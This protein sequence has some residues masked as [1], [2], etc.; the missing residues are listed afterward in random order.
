MED[1]IFKN[2]SMEYKQTPRT[3]KTGA[4]DFSW[5]N[6][7]PAGK[8][9]F[10]KTDGENLVFEDGEKVKFFG[11]N[12]GFGAV[13]PTRRAAEAMADELASVGANFARLHAATFGSLII[14]F[15]DGT[16]QKLNA[17]NLERMDYLIY[18]LK[19]KGIY[20]HF[21]TI[22]G[23][24]YTVKDGFTQEEI[25]YLNESIV[26]A[27]RL[28]DKRCIELDRK[29]II[30]LLDH[31]NP[32][33]GLR[34]ADDPAIAIVQYANENDITWVSTVK[35]KTPFDGILN[36]LYNEWLLKKFGSRD[37]LDKEWT[38]DK[39]EKA[40][41]P[42]ED[43]AKGT[44]RHKP[45]GCWH[46]PMTN[47]TNKYSSE[48][49]SPARHAT[50]MQF[51]YDTQKKTFDYMVEAMKE[52]GVKCLIN[53]SNTVGAGLQRAMNA[54]GDVM[55]T[56][57]YW[58]HP[59][60]PYTV[61]STFHLDAMTDVDP[62]INLGSGFHT[63]SVTPVSH[64]S[65]A[66]KPLIITEWNAA[67]VCQFKADAILQVACYGALQNWSGFLLFAYSFD[68]YVDDDFFGTT[69]YTSFFNSNIDP[70]MWGQ[71]GLAA[72]IF[73]LG[74]VDEAKRYV[75]I[76]VDKTD[77]WVQSPEYTKPAM[78]I[79]F[80]SKYKCKFFDEKY[81][82][83]ADLTISGG[84][85]SSGDY[86]SANHLLLQSFNEYSDEMQKHPARDGWLAKHTEFGANLE[87]LGGF[88]CYV[89]EKHAVAAGKII[90][91]GC[92]EGAPYDKVFTA[93]MRRFGLLS[94]DA[95]WFEDKVVSDTKQLT[96]NIAG[97]FFKAEA[98]KVAVFAG[99]LDKTADFDGLRLVSD[100][101][102]AA[103]AVLS[104][105]GNDI[106]SS[107]H[108]IV[109][110]MGRSGNTGMI[111]DGPQLL[112]LG[113]PPIEFEDIRGSLFIPST[114]AS[115]VSAWICDHNGRRIDEVPVCA[116][117]GGFTLSLKNACYYEISV[118]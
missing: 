60:G 71:F 44:V 90:K 39:G 86:T 91:G 37:A 93:A 40:L 46:E 80:V 17:K 117:D 32:Y 13:A 52:V 11:G 72:A 43:P 97:K 56:N 5:L 113:H 67:T 10:L 35:E 58:N 100:N 109:Y 33:T 102:K 21:D 25:D 41:M 82:G 104:L 96:L 61:P 15:S 9:G 3:P 59:I 65:V 95:G 81:D 69:G 110:A 57:S 88:D 103:V 26:R 34:Y 7:A 63:H 30:D 105:D 53:V 77:L 99:N 115:S 18:C 31:Y 92:F 12:I 36:G 51:L 76:G 1:G 23:R 55:E 54:M 118:D 28:F 2:H 29:L 114:V 89:G 24:S 27:V 98:P 73:R 49:D 50:F 94:D 66:G 64:A 19:K 75:E 22:C 87:N 38:N 6:D 4:F 106:P 68:G 8:H 112:N 101:D 85:T 45:L 42:D 62:R 84:F 78:T 70:S 111:W 116:A 79:P 20:I 74:L 14:D 47:C 16:S 48:A 83:N 108:L 107:K